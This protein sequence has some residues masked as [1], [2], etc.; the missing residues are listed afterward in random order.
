MIRPRLALLNPATL[1]QR[2]RRSHLPPSADLG[3]FIAVAWTL[4]WDLEGHEP[5]T[6]RVISNPCVQIVVDH[7]GAYLLG[8]VTGPYAVTLSGNGF[9]LG[10]RFRPG[11]FH[12]F[13]AGPVAKLTDRRLPLREVLPRVEEDELR[14]QAACANGN[15]ILN[16]LEEALRDAAAPVDPRG[17]VA[18]AIAESIANDATLLTVPQVA[19]QFG[20]SHRTLQRLFRTYVGVGPKWLL[21]RY[22]LQEAAARAE[23]GEMQNWSELALCLGYFDQAH[24]VNDFRRMIGL[25][26]G[27]YLKSIGPNA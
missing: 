4:E 2:C 16:S 17:E 10:V 26:P 19:Q 27:G 3:S 18:C 6:Q 25:P 8:V 11:G 15:G 7:A 13:W 14:R 12:P 5:H 20:V 24:L 21:R 1:A 23:A 9:V 22:R